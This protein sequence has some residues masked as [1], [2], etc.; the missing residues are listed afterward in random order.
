MNETLNNVGLS[1]SLRAIASQWRAKNPERRGGVVLI[2][3]KSVYG[4]KNCLRDAAH[5]QPGA[6]A[7]DAAGHI[8][9]AAGGNEYEGAKCW[10]VLPSAH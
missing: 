8:F 3:Q 5:E 7:V 2:W 9:I 10:V 1:A 4:W 6:Y